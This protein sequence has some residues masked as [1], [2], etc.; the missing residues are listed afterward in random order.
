[1]KCT[2]CGGNLSIDYTPE[3][4]DKTPWEIVC[5]NC[6]WFSM[7]RYATED[8][9]RKGAQM[10]CYRDMTFCQHYESCADGLTCERALTPG[11]LYKASKIG[12]PIC[13]FAEDPECYEEKD[14]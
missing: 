1:M 7:K 14:E 11:V 5:Y 4:N 12:L 10:I 13:Q 8:D 2:T 9:A 3:Y 6:G